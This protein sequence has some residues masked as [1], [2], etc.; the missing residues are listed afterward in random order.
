MI[1]PNPLATLMPIV[2]TVFKYSKSI[3]MRPMVRLITE[4]CFLFM[5]KSRK[6]EEVENMFKIQQIQQVAILLEA[7]P[8][9]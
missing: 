3:L 2:F 4:F 5:R 6:L 1:G 9:S 7:A 8:L